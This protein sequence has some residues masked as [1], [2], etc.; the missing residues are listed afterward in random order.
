MA[1]DVVANFHENVKKES[2]FANWTAF[3]LEKEFISMSW[4]SR[5]KTFR[6]K[7]KSQ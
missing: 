4:N 5:V 6:F 2:V 7:A 1:A 3:S